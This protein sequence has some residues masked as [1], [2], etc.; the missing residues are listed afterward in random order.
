M[1]S[2]RG[3]Q[4]EK[5]FEVL[6][7]EHGYRGVERNVVYFITLKRLSHFFRSE[8]YKRQVDVQYYDGNIVVPKLNIME[9]KYTTHEY[10]ICYEE[11]NNI[12]LD[13]IDKLIGKSINGKEYPG[14]LTLV[15]A[16]KAFLVTNKHFP[17][18]IIEKAK[19]NGIGILQKED[20]IDMI[21][22]PKSGLLELIKDFFKIQKD[23]PKDLEAM[24]RAVSLNKSERKARCKEVKRIIL[25]N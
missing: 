16:D 17:R 25:L 10:P 1:I 21:H 23:K 9:L 6:L 4:F 20:L 14:T 5:M 19:Y 3:Y 15:G 24:I 2:Y 12:R 8:N 13:I 22:E 11:K 18:Y 7:K